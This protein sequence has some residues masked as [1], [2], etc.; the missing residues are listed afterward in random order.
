MEI[1]NHSI[2]FKSRNFLIRDADKVCRAVRSNFPYIAHGKAANEASVKILNKDSIIDYLVKREKILKDYREDRKYITK[3]FNFYKEI[4][5]STINEKNAACYELASLAEMIL[6]LNGISNCTKVSLV[7]KSGKRLNHCVLSV[8]TTDKYDPKKVIIIDPWL[9][10]SGFL[11]EM[12]TKYKHQYGH[13]FK[14]THPKDTVQIQAKPQR[15][16]DEKDIEYLKNRFPK[17][18]MDKLFQK[19]EPL[20]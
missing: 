1:N 13:Y 11:P 6:R 2:S 3:P 7:S 16:L 8:Q 9:Q 20:S 17:L 15:P 14:K 4:L 18:I 19:K 5:Y 10:T 12:L